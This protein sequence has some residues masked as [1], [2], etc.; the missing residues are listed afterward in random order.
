MHLPTSCQV[1]CHTRVFHTCCLHSRSYTCGYRT[2]T[3]QGLE[4]SVKLEAILSAEQDHRV[5]A[6]HSLLGWSA[7]ERGRFEIKILECENAAPTME[8]QPLKGAQAAEKSTT[9]SPGK[10]PSVIKTNPPR[11]QKPVANAKAPAPPK[12]QAQS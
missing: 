9:V 4:Y 7:S 10:A 12:T 3:W 6:A 2:C 5:F 11:T 8:P 1:S